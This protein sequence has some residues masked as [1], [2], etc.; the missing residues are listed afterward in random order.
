M[1]LL[2]SGASEELNLV[3]GDIWI[4]LLIISILL[5]FVLMGWVFFEITLL[6]GQREEYKRLN[7]KLKK[8]AKENATI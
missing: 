3:A 4:V 1:A 8:E 7:Q 5:I 6:I 2:A